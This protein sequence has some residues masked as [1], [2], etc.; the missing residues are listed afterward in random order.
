MVDVAL[1]PHIAMV[2]EDNH[3]PEPKPLVGVRMIL[4][5]DRPQQ[6]LLCS[7]FYGTD[8][9]PDCFQASICTA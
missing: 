2:G 9:V 5:P 6:T 3:P 4:R 7:R 8:G 1:I